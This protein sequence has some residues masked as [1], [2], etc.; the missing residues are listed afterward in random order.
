MTANERKSGVSL[1]FHAWLLLHETLLLLDLV[2]WEYDVE[3]N[4]VFIDELAEI[5]LVFDPHAVSFLTHFF[6]LFSANLFLEVTFNQLF[7][8]RLK[9][10]IHLEQARDAIT[11]QRSK[12]GR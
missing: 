12:E 8:N 4:H 6:G 11:R 5:Y 9:H 3:T 2:A 1:L 10:E 7:S